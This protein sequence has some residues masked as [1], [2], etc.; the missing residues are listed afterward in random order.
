M[1]ELSTHYKKELVSL[2]KKRHCE[3]VDALIG[4]VT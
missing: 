2:P 1:M 3:N 4:K